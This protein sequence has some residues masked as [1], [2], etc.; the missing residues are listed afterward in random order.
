MNEAERERIARVLDQAAPSLAEQLAIRS[1][2]VRIARR[3]LDLQGSEK[4]R[5]LEQEAEFLQ[6]AERAERGEDVEWP[7]STEYRM[8]L[9]DAPTTTVTITD[10][11]ELDGLRPADADR[12]PECSN[13]TPHSNASLSNCSADAVSSS[14]AVGGARRRAR[15]AARSAARSSP[16]R[17]GRGAP[18]T[19]ASVPRSAPSLDEN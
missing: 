16:R 6:L 14:S 13:S 1:E 17:A 9:V 19:V 8:A 5:S 2:A 15:S 7:S 12:R 11:A 18:P 3:S 4:R 10:T